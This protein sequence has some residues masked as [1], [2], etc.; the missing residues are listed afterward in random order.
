MKAKVDIDLCVGC[1]L[2]ADACPAVF[3]MDEDKA[4]VKVNHVPADYEEECQ[5]AKQDCPVEAINIEE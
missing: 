2:C 4:K 3:V 5:K 1:G